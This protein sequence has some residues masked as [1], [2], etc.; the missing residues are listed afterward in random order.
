[1]NRLITI[2]FISAVLLY[3]EISTTYAADSASEDV[4]KTAAI[5]VMLVAFT[6]AFAISAFLTYRIRMRKNNMQKQVNTTAQEESPN[7]DD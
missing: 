6:A 5:I 7:H 4:S 3:G 2:I 1:M